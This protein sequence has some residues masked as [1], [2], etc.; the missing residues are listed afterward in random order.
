MPRLLPA[1]SNRPR[2]KASALE[3]SSPAAR[4]IAAPPMNFV[5]PALALCLLVVSAA[6][7]EVP[8]TL[9]QDAESFTLA[10]GQLT[11]RVAKRSG[12]LT[13]LRFRGFELLAWRGSGANGGYWSAVGSARA[14][15]G[16][17]ASVIQDPA[18]NGGERVEIS[19]RLLAGEGEPPAP[20]EMDLRYSLGRGEAGLYTYAIW[21]HAAGWP[22]L[23][24]GE[25]RYCLKLNPEVFD[26]FTVD[27]ARRRLMP[28]PAD[29][30]QGTPLNLKEARRMTTGV[31]RGEAEHKYGYSAV[32][33]EMPAYGWSSTRQNIGLWL[34]NPCLEFIAGGPTKLELTGHLDVNPGGTPTLLNMWLGSH[35][36]GSSL[37]VARE[38]EWTKV[39]GPFLVFCN[40]LAEP[41][42]NA[43]ASAAA[44]AAQ[45]RLWQAALAHAASEAA[46][47]PYAW[48]K[49]PAYPLAGERGTV[50]GRL[51]L[52]DPFAPQQG[53]TNAWLGLTAPDY[54]P[55]GFGRQSFGGT[56]GP[57]DRAAG[58]SPA[59]GL[60]RSGFPTSVDWQRDAKFYQFWVRPDAQG[61][62]TLRNIRPGTYTLRAISDGV[63][64]EFTVTNVTVATGETK[65]LGTLKW[66]PVRHGRTVWQIGI[67]NR[68]AHEFR[69]GTNAWQW[70]TYFKYAGEFP[71]D[72]N[73]V[74]GQ[75]DW[76]R[77][78]NYVQPPRWVAATNA[79]AGAVANGE[80]DDLEAFPWRQ[81]VQSTTWKIRFELP[82][83]PR[84]R[85]TLRLAFT[86]T[87]AG[88]NVEAAVN[89]QP[90]GET[91]PLPST[92]AMQ[93]DGA[94][95]YWIERPLTFDAARLKAGENVITL[96]SRA[97]SWSQGVMYDVV[98]LE[99]ADLTPAEK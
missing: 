24:A 23:G 57:T 69:N 51:V 73:F 90:I 66:Q 5:F 92:S 63:I 8:V 29:W 43:P 33:A 27:A 89:G 48:L 42:T 20:V 10:N 64:G 55:S 83:V 25:A 38:E 36:G 34:I 32:L 79:V 15:A 75:S 70:G 88:C 94:H 80:K 82:A 45:A 6:A 99:L 16:R 4:P 54:Q 60:G 13:S 14:G 47:W 58:S 37:S 87:H 9:A 31:H 95:A 3:T 97:T 62:F 39:I 61:S 7:A 19:C 44:H 50:A 52:R 93:R 56:S 59:A 78:W 49:H 98:R 40:A 1:S 67:P 26:F 91:G 2:F 71:N 85:A 84:G 35:Y 22:A 74:I 68:T 30:D 86:G 12:T 41:Q 65:P 72:V 17:V 77:D 28:S 46:R 21:R 53:L 11:A 81:R 18:N 96:R 76:R